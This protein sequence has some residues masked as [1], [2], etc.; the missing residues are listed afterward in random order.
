[1]GKSEVQR[2][3]ELGRCAFCGKQLSTE[4]EKNQNLCSRC[5]DAR[6]VIKRNVNQATTQSRK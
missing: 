5:Y 3:I 1:M 2:N 4:N 6:R